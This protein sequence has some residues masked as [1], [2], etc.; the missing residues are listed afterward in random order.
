MIKRMAAQPHTPRRGALSS[1][2]E[3]EAPQRTPGTRTENGDRPPGIGRQMLTLVVNLVAPIALYYGLRSMGVGIYL[4]LV[5]G[6]MAPA[7][8][9]VVALIRRDRVNGLG[10]FMMTMV[11]LSAGVSLLTGGPRFL[12]AKDGWLTGVSGLWMLFSVRGQRPLTFLFARPL[13]EGV[14]AKMA[15]SAGV[16]WDILWERVP[17]FRR[18]WRVATVIWGSALLVDAAIRVVMAYTLPIDVVPALGGALWP[19]T[20]IVLQV[21]TNVYFGRAGFWLILRGRLDAPPARQ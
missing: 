8:G 3:R 5:I 2:R 13:L 16:S 19:V 17:R 15:G 12:L 4:T 6:A 18:I 11:L 7:L 1:E 21:I 10:L 14:A 9:V 20:F